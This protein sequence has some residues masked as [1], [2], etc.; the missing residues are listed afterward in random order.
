MTR[1]QADI[2]VRIMEW[3]LTQRGARRDHAIMVSDGLITA[4]LR[5]IDTHGV[6]LFPVYL[7]ELDGGRA[8]ARPVLSWQ[9][10]AGAMRVLDAGGALGL[11][12]GRIASDEAVRLAKVHGV[13]SVAVRGSNHFGAASAYTLRMAE[14]DVVGMSFSN[15]DALVAP[16]GG[17][18]P[19]FGTNPLSVAARGLGEEMFCVDM[20]T[21]QSSYSKIKRQR[22]RGEPVEP[23]LA[24][25]ADGRDLSESR[26]DLA[27]LSPL[28]GYKGQCLSMLVEL[29]C[30]L[31][32][33]AP[34]DH[35]LSHLYEPP[36]DT[37]RN[38]SHLFV[39]FDIARLGNVTSFRAR[40]SQW[41]SVTRDVPGIDGQEVLVPG[42]LEAASLRERSQHGIPMDS[43]LLQAFRR[44][45][46]GNPEPEGI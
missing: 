15:S 6:A 4:S 36:Y 23:G 12:A 7:Q 26:G 43:A 33:G 39:A 40:L 31:L 5:G 38:V 3:A 32:A 35:E 34:W 29:L 19:L 30:A 9:G 8:R 2:L 37:P 25:A 44:I 20:A 17:A 27:A 10:K 16:S 24:I 28:G 46:A 14:K 22:E 11:V 18:Q 13:G 41:L 45:D 42:D 1:I 21:S